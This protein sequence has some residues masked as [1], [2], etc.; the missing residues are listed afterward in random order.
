MKS[1]SLRALATLAMA[2]AFPGVS[3]VHANPPPPPPASLDASSAPPPEPIQ[4]A[5]E[6][7]PLMPHLAHRRGVAVIADF[8]N[9]TL[10]DWQGEGLNA[11][12]EFRTELDK[13]EAHWAW[14]SHGK[15]TFAWDI[16][17]IT[18]PV[19]LGPEAFP[20]G[21]PRYREAVGALIRQ[22]I[23]VDA[24]DAN[25]DGIVDSA[26]VIA[27]NQGQAFDYL[28]SGASRNGGVNMFV[29]G[30]ADLAVVLQTTGN[31]NHELG[32]T[33]GLP[34]IY[35]PYGTLFY[36]TVMADSWPVP[37]QDFSAFEKTR[38]GWLTP[39]ELG[40]GTHE[41]KLH[42]ST[43]RLDALRIPT[44]RPSEYFL[45]EYRRRPDSGFASVAPPYDGLAVYHVLEGSHQRIDPP[46]LKL[47]AADGQIAPETA[48][49]P[50]DFLYPGNPAMQQPLVLRSYFANLPIAAID[51]VAWAGNGRLAFRVR[52]LPR[53]PAV[54]GNFLLKNRLR[55]PSFERGGEAPDHWFT[56][57]LEPVSRLEWDDDVA[58]RGRRSVSI[59][60]PGANDARWEQT[61]SGLTPGHAYQLCGWLRGRNL[62]VPPQDAVG[63]HVSVVN[64][65]DRS[66]SFFRT[67]DWRQACLVHKPAHP[68]ATYACRLGESFSP[69]LGKTWCDDMTLYPVES[70]FD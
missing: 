54:L 45:I 32:H 61:V 3:P 9:A 8:A 5:Q 48:P 2:L 29:N 28:A 34:D 49:G 4:E 37:P 12:A 43:L 44:S 56:Q 1:M 40:P 50:D 24:Y 27:A 13:M 53:L 39:R 14:M 6:T 31:F 30:Q 41:V 7:L 26:F 10:E 19:T 20:G 64:E 55:N 59:T 67:F 47:E 11:V 70:A 16:V 52:V 23:D 36:L 22:Q 62:P 25:D 33:L 17:R 63:A 46:L 57:A 66:D 69:A 15:E 18:L 51:R 38:L 35:G 65:P 21:W 58:H 68:V 60:S 42:A